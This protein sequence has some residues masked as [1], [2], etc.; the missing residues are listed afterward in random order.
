MLTAQEARSI[1]EKGISVL[2]DHRTFSLSAGEPFLEGNELTYFDGRSVTICGFPLRGVET[3]SG[4][5]QRERVRY[6]AGDGKAESIIYIGPAPIE[7][8][9]LAK[10]G[11]R[12]VWDHPRSKFEAEL[13]AQCAEDPRNIGVGKP[14]RSVRASKFAVEL[15]AAG[16]VSHEYL[17][18]IERFFARQELS[19]YLVS[20]SFSINA[21]LRARGVHLVGA[22]RGTE[23]VGFAVLHK[24][25]SDI[26][27]A[28]C[29]FHDGVTSGVSDFLYAQVLALGYRIGARFVNLGSSPTK[30]IYRF[31]QKWGGRPMVAP[32]YAVCWA[33][34]RLARREFS[35]WGP[36]LIRFPSRR[37]W[38]V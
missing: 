24:P 36:R 12:R 34:G 5:Q 8:G 32:Y 26:A 4:R 2:H 18:L 6:W 1:R 22:R 29:L 16:I 14:F 21:L 11:L 38:F 31:K 3:R 33:K 9:F 30:G 7:F 17:S 23:L 10:C 37:Y 25:F 35:G 20:L 19:P 13:V 28:E 27:V 15:G